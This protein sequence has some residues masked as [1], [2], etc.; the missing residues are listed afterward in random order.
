MKEDREGDGGGR[1]IPRT[2]L[3]PEKADLE[4]RDKTQIHAI[5]RMKTR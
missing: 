3:R 1:E 5:K 4:K 2:E